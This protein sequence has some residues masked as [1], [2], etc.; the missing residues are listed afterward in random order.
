V[1]PDSSFVAHKGDINERLVL[2]Q[3]IQR[4]QNVVLVVVPSQAVARGARFARHF[5]DLRFFG[6]RP[7]SISHDLE[8]HKTQTSHPVLFTSEFISNTGL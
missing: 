4:V 1:R 8:Q 6:Q 3:R 2:Q 7:P 5:P